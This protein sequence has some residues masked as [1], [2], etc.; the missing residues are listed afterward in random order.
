M[1]NKIFKYNA[2]ISYRHND[3]DKYVDDNKYLTGG[4]F[5]Y[6]HK[7][8]Q[9]IQSFENEESI[10]V[11]LSGMLI[12]LRAV[13]EK[14]LVLISSRPSLSSASVRFLQNINDW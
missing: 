4:D 8:E 7:L 9:E 2:F 6:F 12:S 14:A 13:F 11:T 3:L 1:E 5:D 10:L